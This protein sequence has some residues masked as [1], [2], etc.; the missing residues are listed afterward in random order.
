MIIIT[1]FKLNYNI[2]TDVFSIVLKDQA[3]TARCPL[4]NC[5][6]YYR[7]R[8]SRDLKNLIG[9]KRHFSLRR[10][11]CEGC[12]KHHTEIPDIIQPYKHYDSETIQCVLDGSKEAEECA[13]DN[14][15]IRRWK[16]SFSKAE[17]DITQRLTSVYAQMSDA[18]PPIGPTA[19][20]LSTI[21]TM[22]EQWLAFVMALLIN[23]GHKICTQFAFC[24]PS[25]V[26]IVNIIIP[27][28]KT[29]TKGE[30]KNDKSIED[31]N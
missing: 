23:N 28:N 31:T 3:A 21:Q 17:P 16:V 7:D 24:P 30:G 13:A 12:G 19:P 1:S 27:K 18:T 22:V 26:D 15:T 14:S 9:E 6:V 2:L 20:T 4:C 29:I 25:L 10:L 5:G 11:R 8:K